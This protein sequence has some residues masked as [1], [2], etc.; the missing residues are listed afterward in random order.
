M[1]HGPPRDEK[2]LPNVEALS[3]MT[4][5]DFFALESFGEFE[6]SYPPDDGPGAAIERP[7]LP[8]RDTVL[9]PH[10]VTPLF[11]GRDRSLRAIDA[12]MTTNQ[13]LVVVSQKDEETQNPGFEDLYTIGTEVII[14]RML[15]MPDGSTSILAQGQNRVEILEFLETESYVVARARVLHEPELDDL[16]TEGD[17]RSKKMAEQNAAKKAIAL[18]DDSHT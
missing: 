13:R 17:G 1:A 18:L 9:F 12:A 14:G 10:M 2:T 11:V 5:E 4:V 8:V 16:M 6:D 3:L 7:L 15:R